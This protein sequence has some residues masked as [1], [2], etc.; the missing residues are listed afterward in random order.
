M[1][2][3]T[4]GCPSALAIPEQVKARIAA[5]EEVRD[6]T[7]KSCGNQ[8]GIEHDQ[9]ER[10]QSAWPRSLTTLQKKTANL[11]IRRRRSLGEHKED[12]SRKKA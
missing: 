9:R 11:S 1:T 6:V 7:V 8:P 12:L 2:L 10:A 5:I 4:Q 3:T